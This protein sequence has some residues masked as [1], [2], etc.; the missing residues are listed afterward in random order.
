MSRLIFSIL[1][2]ST[3]SF[4]SLVNSGFIYSDLKILED[5]D[6]DRSFITDPKLQKTYQRIINN[7]QKRYAK[8]LNDAHLFVPKIKQ[9]LKEND[10]P[11]AFL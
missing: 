2:L 7:N 11:P 5:L 1:L 4:A 10:I 8:H 6:L 3:I 9:I